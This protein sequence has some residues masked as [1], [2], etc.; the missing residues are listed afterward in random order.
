MKTKTTLLTAATLAA[1]MLL[2]ACSTKWNVTEVERTRLLVDSRYDKAPHKE[3]NDFLA[4]YKQKVDSVMSS[5]VGKAACYMAA[6]RPESKLSNLLGDILVWEGL[7]RGEKP[8]FS[9][10]NMGGM[11]AAFSQ[12]DVTYGDVLAVAPFENKICF[13]TLTGEKTLELCRQLASIQGEGVSHGFRMVIG[14]DGSLKS[15]TIH[16][17]EIDAKASY[18]I[19]TLDYLAQGNG[20]LTAFKS[21]TDLISPQDEANNVRFII[22]DYFKAAM[23]EGKAVDSNIEGRITIE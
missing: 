22:M 17:K 5:V 11:R 15:V 3:G 18:R 7:R 4:P 13:L 14:K 6:Q 21:A 8:D 2:T 16:G 20:G 12:G 10:Y 19:A 23:T 9:V 1:T